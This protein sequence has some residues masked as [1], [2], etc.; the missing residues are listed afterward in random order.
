MASHDV[1]CVMCP[2]L[3]AGLQAMLRAGAGAGAA[4]GAGAGAGEASDS[5]AAYGAATL[6]NLAATPAL[7]AAILRAAPELL[8]DLAALLTTPLPPAIAKSHEGI[9]RDAQSH[10]GLQRDAQSQEVLAHSAQ[11][12]DGLQRDAQS[13]EVLAHSAQSHDGLQRDAQSQEVLAHSAQSH[14]AVAS[15]TAVGVIERLLEAPGAWAIG[16]DSG[17]GGYGGGNGD[18]DGDGGGGGGDGNG[19]DSLHGQSLGGIG[20]GEG[21][22]V[23]F[24]VDR[25]LGVLPAADEV[26]PETT[27]RGLPYSYTYRDPSGTARK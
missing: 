6:G 5:S 18:G 23:T 14:L 17:S 2:A 4:S 19:V 1:V 20:S 21:D 9:Q 7:Q 13:Q 15:A 11:S 25:L 27:L 24:L 26:G 12:H 22:L 8:R 3:V 16:G 10:D